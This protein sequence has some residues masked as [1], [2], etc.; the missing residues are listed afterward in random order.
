MTSSALNRAQLAQEVVGVRL[1][2]LLDEAAFVG[3]AEDVDQF[4][5]HS[6]AV[7]LDD[8]DR[9]RNRW[10][11]LASRPA[12]KRRKTGLWATGGNPRQPLRSW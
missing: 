10:Q 2:P 3:V 12:P 5:L 7:R 8:S 6:L 9:R 4:P 11:P 1:H